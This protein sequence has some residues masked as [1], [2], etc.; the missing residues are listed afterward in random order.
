MAKP[1]SPLRL[2]SKVKHKHLAGQGKI[3]ELTH[4]NTVATVEATDKEGK[5]HVHYVRVSELKRAD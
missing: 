4:E 2:G 1:T 3:I 5:K